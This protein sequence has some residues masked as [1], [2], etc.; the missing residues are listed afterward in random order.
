M[1]H[2][3][4]GDTHRILW[5]LQFF[6]HEI[7]SWQ[8]LS[9]RLPGSAAMPGSGSAA[10]TRQHQLQ[11]YD[12]LGKCLDNQSIRDTVSHPWKLTWHWKIPISNRKYIFKWWIFHCHINFFWGWV[13][14]SNLL[15]NFVD[16]G[17]QELHVSG[18]SSSHNHGSG[19]WVPTTLVSSIMGPLSTSTIMGG[20]VFL[21]KKM[22]GML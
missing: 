22:L 13:D 9:T 17:T 2:W 20:R 21:G 8:L 6:S 11:T 15:G 12:S 5:A 3:L 14:I 10:I 1:A 4:L 18:Y 19:E 7:H 16:T